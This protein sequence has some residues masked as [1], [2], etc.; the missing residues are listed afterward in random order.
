[1][2]GSRVRWVKM[3]RTFAKQGRPWHFV[4]VSFS[5]G[6]GRHGG[7]QGA[8]GAVQGLI[9]CVR[10]VRVLAE[11]PVGAWRMA[12]PSASSKGP[13][14]L[15]CHARALTLRGHTN[16]GARL[17]GF[18]AQDVDKMWTGCDQ[19]GD[20]AEQRPQQ[21]HSIASKASREGRQ[22]LVFPGG[23]PRLG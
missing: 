5:G 11:V 1:M 16:Y 12:L 9:L 20:A 19:D 10:L 7:G 8:V 22:G 17:A 18:F 4:L 23:M 14:F 6:G 21:R 15:V 13:C 2:V 3:K